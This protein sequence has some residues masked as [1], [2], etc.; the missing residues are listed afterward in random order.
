MRDFGV[1]HADEKAYREMALISLAKELGFN[2]E[3]VNYEPQPD[4][5][6]KS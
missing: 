5:E 1:I 4:A 2:R 3:F 6:V